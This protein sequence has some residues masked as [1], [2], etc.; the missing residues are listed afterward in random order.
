MVSD[1]AILG[2]VSNLGLKKPL[3]I[4]RL[5][6]WFIVLNKKFNHQQ[7]NRPQICV[8]SIFR[9]VMEPRW[10]Y[11]EPTG[12]ALPLLSSHRQTLPLAAANI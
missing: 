1:P 9:V 5:L 10:P 12:P 4:Q 2:K 8:Q 3:K 7:K 6:G 11:S